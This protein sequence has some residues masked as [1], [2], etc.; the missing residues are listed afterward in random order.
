MKRVVNYIGLGLMAAAAVAMIAGDAFAG[1]PSSPLQPTA[2]K[3][4]LDFDMFAPADL[5]CDATGPGVRTRATRDIAGKPVLRIT[6]NAVDAE[7]SCSLPDGTQFQT[8]VNRDRLLYNTM[9]P[10]YATVTFKSGA[11][12]MTTVL[13]Q[14]DRI[15]HVRNGSFLRVA[16]GQNGDDGWA[17]SLTSLG[18]RTA[19]G[20]KD[21]SVLSGD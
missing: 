11:D 9:Y 2:Q 8:E 17:S 3:F 15:K 18:G 10:T 13:R 4:Y 6:G 5:S 1:E 20:A 7:I 21:A 12:R 14:N 19:A 16:Q